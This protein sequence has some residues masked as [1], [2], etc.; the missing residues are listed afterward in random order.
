VQEET[1]LQLNDAR[2]LEAF[3]KRVAFIVH[4]IKNTMGQLSLVVNNVARFGHE[5]EFRKD[6]VTTIRHSVDQLQELLWRLK[7]EKRAAATKS[8]EVVDVVGLISE[9]VSRKRQGGLNITMQSAD[10]APVITEIEN[11]N[12]F[13]R[14]LDHIVNNALEAAPVGSPVKI[15]IEKVGDRVRIYID[16][17]G[18]GMTPQFITDELF[19]PLRTTKGKG[20]G[21]GAYQAK[22]TMRELG[23]DLQVL[24][25]VGQGTTVSLLLPVR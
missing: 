8:G 5:E 4:D 3:N 17:E 23:G 22:E 14:V 10:I 19:R 9:F 2:Q 11:R 7:G 1:A 12:A 21:I 20:L 6:M 18:A 24:S 25:T 15:G 13:V 16:D